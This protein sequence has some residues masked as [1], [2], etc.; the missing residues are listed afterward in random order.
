[1]TSASGS[2]CIFT[3]AVRKT[4]IWLLCIEIYYTF[5]FYNREHVLICIALLASGGLIFLIQPKCK[6]GTDVG[7][8]SVRL[9]KSVDRQHLGRW[10]TRRR[11]GLLKTRSK[12][13]RARVL[14]VSNR[15]DHLSN[16]PLSNSSSLNRRPC[17]ASRAKKPSNKSRS[18][19]NEK[20]ERR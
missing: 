20:K 10:S 8:W 14:G 4:P 13:I 16:V 18:N 9:S 1:M 11:Q 17:G 5:Y 2:C 15:P 7:R 6:V 19:Q 12:S 3:L